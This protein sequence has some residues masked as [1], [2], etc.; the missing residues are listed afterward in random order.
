MDL[1]AIS[2]NMDIKRFLFT[3]MRVRYLGVSGDNYIIGCPDP[4]HIDKHPSCYFHKR[5]LIYHCFGC[6]ARGN[7][8]DLIVYTQDMDRTD[9]LK[10]IQRHSGLSL[11]SV[12]ST[13]K[14]RYQRRDLGKVM[15]S[16][17]YQR[18]WEN[19]RDEIVS[20]VEKRHFNLALF[21]RY[22]IGFNNAI[23]SISLPVVYFGRVVNVGER[24]VLGD[25]ATKIKYRKGVPLALSVWGI[26]ED[27]DPVDPYFTEG[28][29][30]ALRMREAGLNAYALLSIVLTNEKMRFILEHFEGTFTIV[31]D[32]DQGGAKMI[33]YWKKMIHYTEVR[34]LQPK[35]DD[36]DATPIPE[37]K[38]LAGETVRMQDYMFG[39]EGYSIKDDICESSRSR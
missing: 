5:N 23:G 27:Y 1:E 24:F 28:I 4:M 19:A 33:E 29:F 35:D 8:I 21:D 34:I 36:I 10:L 16:S 14:P 22:Y 13:F 17:Q 26:F 38:R 32:P 37:I 30:D 25:A 39:S 31:P 7:I 11:N 6:G 3:D 9:A 15:L 20:F 2:E 18:D 12:S